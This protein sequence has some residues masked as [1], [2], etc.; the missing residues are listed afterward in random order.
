MK[1][2][3]SDLI[4][5][6]ESAIAFKIQPENGDW[7]DFIPNEQFNEVLRKVVNS[8]YNN[9]A[10]FHKPFWISGTYGSGKSHAGA[11][12]KHLLCDPIDDIREYIECEY[13]D[14]SLALLRSDIL[15]LRSKKRLFPVSLYGIVN[16][17]AA[18][19]L[20]FVLQTHIVDALNR[21]GIE[22]EVQTDFDHYIADIEK[23]GEFWSL[24]IERD[25][26]LKALAPSTELLIDK[27]S[28]RDISVIRHI[29]NAL[30]RQNR[31]IPLQSDDL[32]KWIFE[33]Q[34]KLAAQGVYDG[35]L[36]VWD[37]FTDVLKSAFGLS[38]LVTLQ[39][40]SERMM[41]AK[42]NSYFLF[43]SHPSALDCLQVEEREKTKGRYHY[44]PYNMETV[45]AY[46]IMSRKFR[47]IDDDVVYEHKRSAF[48]GPHEGLYS[49]FAEISTSTHN[50]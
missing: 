45:S 22:F 26:Q 38:A 2:K 27:L 6:R 44:M 43:I 21:E 29:K 50:L 39:G 11:V 1:T 46:K 13:R 42:N 12:I 31:V 40:I 48:I 7:R 17:A 10:D 35:L 3:Y 24:I 23:D 33:V 16:M 37:E 4:E 5:I 15:N 19:D 28:D 8:V 49:E 9:N 18:E 41:M 30:R 14:E 47:I 36:I 32:E 25:A 34:D 20:P